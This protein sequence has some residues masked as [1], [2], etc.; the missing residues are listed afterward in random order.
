MQSLIFDF[1]KSPYFFR[2]WNKEFDVED[3]ET[4]CFYI[5]LVDDSC[6]DNIEENLNQDHQLIY[7]SEHMIREECLLKYEETDTNE[8]ITLDGDVEITLESD[9]KMR[10]CFLCA[11]SGFVLGYSI[12]TYSLNIS[13]AITFEDGL[14]FFSLTDEV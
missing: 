9:F 8:D 14:F 2:K 11:D 6:E 3:I 7:D 4:N 10:G 12:N 1:K 5:I 13:S